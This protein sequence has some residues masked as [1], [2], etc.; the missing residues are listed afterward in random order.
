MNP[1]STAVLN[2]GS[3]PMRLYFHLVNEFWAIY[4]E[5]GL[6]FDEGTSAWSVIEREVN[7]FLGEIP[8]EYRSGW[9]LDVVDDAGS[10]YMSI[11]LS[12]AM[13]QSTRCLR[14]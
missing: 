12:E 5:V 14:H 11:A 9:H 13:R 8:E 3:I 1:A 10:L 7:D 2:Q 6:D 4:D